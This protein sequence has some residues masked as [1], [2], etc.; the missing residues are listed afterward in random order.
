MIRVVFSDDSSSA[1]RS[2]HWPEGRPPTGSSG[3]GIIG[4]VGEYFPIV[5]LN[6]ALYVVCDVTAGGQDWKSDWNS[7]TSPEGPV[8]TERVI[9]R[10]SY[11]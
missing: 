7:P 11:V 5:G 1:I 10:F 8:L 9:E 3:L 4:A 2:Y 6:L